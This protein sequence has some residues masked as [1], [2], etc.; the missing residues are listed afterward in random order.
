MKSL[1]VHSKRNTLLSILFSILLVLVPATLPSVVQAKDK[2]PQ[3]FTTKDLNTLAGIVKLAQANDGAVTRADLDE[4]L[5]ILI[6]KAGFY[7]LLDSEGGVDFN[8]F[9][10]LEPFGRKSYA[11][12]SGIPLQRNADGSLRTEGVFD[13]NGNLLFTRFFIVRDAQGHLTV[14]LHIERDPLKGG[15]F[16]KPFVPFT[17]G[18]Q[19]GTFDTI[20]SGDLVGL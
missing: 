2:T 7:Q 12:I 8:A 17:A 1:K 10:Q 20:Q 16:D 9:G 13:E 6:G 4:G 11:K 18:R 15:A 19:P 5:R 3:Q 14:N